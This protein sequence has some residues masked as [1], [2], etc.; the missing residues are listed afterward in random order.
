M[1]RT[2]MNFGAISLCALSGSVKADTIIARCTDGTKGAAFTTSSLD[3]A[4]IAFTIG[5]ALAPPPSP[6]AILVMRDNA[7]PVWSVRTPRAIH[8]SC[9]GEG[10]PVIDLFGPV[11]ARNGKWKVA[12]TST[13]VEGCPPEAAAAAAGANG[14]NV[15]DI[16]WPTPFSPAPLMAGHGTWEQTGLQQWRGVIAQTVSDQASATVIADMQVVSDTEITGTNVMTL[17]LPPMIAKMIG[18]TGTCRSTTTATYRW[19][20]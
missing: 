15:M 3:P 13:N 10:E 16:V 1:T 8:A 4:D 14:T 6:D 9:G 19:Q 12:L 5:H 2:V 20:E 11:I 18:S 17:T 7:A